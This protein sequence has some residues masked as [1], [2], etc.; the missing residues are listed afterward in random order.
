[1]LN[2]N[3]I[4]LTESA[5]EKL[6]QL[7]EKNKKTLYL[8]IS[9]GGCSGFQYN[10]SLISDA[11]VPDTFAVKQDGVVVYIAKQSLDFIKGATIDHKKS[12]MSESFVI[13]N[14]VAKVSCG[15]GVSFDIE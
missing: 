6:T 1:M 5:V 4:F 15:C 2:D 7:N 8:N 12:L 9:G 11:H 13:N 3:I 10:L 14:P